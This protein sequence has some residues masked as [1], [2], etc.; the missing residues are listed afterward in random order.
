MTLA[1]Q[2]GFKIVLKTTNTLLKGASVDLPN[3]KSK[4]QRVV[5]AIGS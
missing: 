3:H 2:K 1:E 4:D 5:R